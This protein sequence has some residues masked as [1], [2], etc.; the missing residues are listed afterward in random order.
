MWITIEEKEGY[1]LSDTGELINKKQ[2][3]VY[4]RKH[5]NYSIVR[6]KGKDVYIHQ[7]VAKYF[8]P[9]PLY[10]HSKIKHKDKN[11]QNN[12]YHNLEYIIPLSQR[13][14]PPKIKP[15]KAPRHKECT[16]CGTT[17]VALFHKTKWTVCIS[18]S[19]ARAG[20]CTLH[21]E[22]GESN[23]DNFYPSNKSRCKK[24]VGRRFIKWKSEHP[25]NQPE[26]MHKFKVR[27]PLYGVLKN[28]EHRSKK[29]KFEFS[30]TEEDILHQLNEQDNKCY[31]SGIPIDVYN[32]SIDRINAAIG[33]VPSNIKLTTSRINWMKGNMT[34]RD[35][36]QLISVIYHY[37]QSNNI[38]E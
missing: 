20:V 24:C 28:A 22:C 27:N 4:T 37:T 19:R 36:I 3:P 15:S 30:L 2:E 25:L 26:S 6:I 32:L 1:Q 5:R 12:D 23:P 38:Q 16:D 31:F 11:R 33:Y 9:P 34:N 18:C 8:L 13:V 29:K 17:D 21:C 35:F 10:P 14:S 7:L